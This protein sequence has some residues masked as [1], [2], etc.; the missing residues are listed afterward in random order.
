MCRC[1]QVGIRTRGALVQAVTQKA[2]RLPTVAADQAASIVNFVASDIQKIYD[3]AMVGAQRAVC[4]VS[5]CELRLLRPVGG[6]GSCTPGNRSIADDL[7]VSCPAISSPFLSA[8]LAP[9][10]EFHYLW[11]AP[12]EAAAIL[13]LLGY[14][15]S[16]AML[17]GLAVLFIVSTACSCSAVLNCCCMRTRGPR[18]CGTVAQDASYR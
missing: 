5:A 7:H 1:T 9:P 3:G 2:F 10:Q 6:T 12:L 4:G 13:A 11:T 17:P 8:V 18:G 14:L 15:T 16:D